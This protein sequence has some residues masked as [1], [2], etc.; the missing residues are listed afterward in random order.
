MK[1]L[2]FGS[3][4]MLGRDLLGMLDQKNFFVTGIDRERL[5][6]RNQDMIRPVLEDDMPDMVVNCAAYTNVDLA[7]KERD[8]ALKI[9]R[10]AP[11]KLASVCSEMEIPLL[12]ISTDYVFNGNTDTSYRETDQTEPVNF[13]GYSKLL[14]ELAVKSALCEH[15]ILRTSWLYGR[16][17]KNFVKT[18]LELARKRDELR[19]VSDQFGSPTW[20][21][22]LAG[23]IVKLVEFVGS[24]RKKVRWGIYHYSGKGETSWY[25]FACKIVEYARKYEKLFVSRIVPI[26]SSQYSTP[27][28][29]P[30]RSV[31]NCEKISS[32]FGIHPGPWELSLKRMIDEYYND[33]C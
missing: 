14:G 1:I 12:H 7:E 23:A 8:L 15:L 25:G 31:L 24:D 27:A 21:K 19:I 10:D 2:V 9:N 13:Y 18:V 11:L 30:G 29:R 5:D 3:S 33:R 17:G 16:H 4:G 22:D 26:K 28:R 6:L 20:T 32:N